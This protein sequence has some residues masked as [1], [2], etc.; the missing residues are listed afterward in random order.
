M[1]LFSSS[2]K[3]KTDLDPN[4]KSV[5]SSQPNICIG[6]KVLRPSSQLENIFFRANYRQK[7]KTHKPHLVSKGQVR[8][9]ELY[10]ILAWLCRSWLSCNITPT[11]WHNQCYIQDPDSLRIACQNLFFFFCIFHLVWHLDRCLR[12]ES[13]CRPVERHNAPWRSVATRRR[14][15]A[16]DLI[17]SQHQPL[18]PCCDTQRDR[19]T[20]LFF[21]FFE[22]EGR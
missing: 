18:F 5:V 20:I 16:P 15:A 3:K 1:R 13:W 7:T 2:I 19:A 8:L 12:H 9:H 4:N 11:V 17:S 10:Q 22:E 21:F 6:V 14:T